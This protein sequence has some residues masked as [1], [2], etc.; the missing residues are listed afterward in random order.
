MSKQ[1][2]ALIAVAATAVLISKWFYDRERKKRENPNFIPK[3]LLAGDEEE[4][5]I[6][7][8]QPALKK[9]ALEAR[10]LSNIGQ[11]DQLMLYGLYK[12]ATI[13]NSNIDPPSKFRIRAYAKHQAWTKF[14]GM[15]RQFAILKY[16]EVVTHFGKLEQS[17][18][19]DPN[20]LSKDNAA[21]MNTISMIT[22]ES[23]ADIEYDK[24]Q[25]YDGE[26]LSDDDEI[27]IRRRN[28][29]NEDELASSLG[30]KQSTLIQG[31]EETAL[32]VD[33]K[34]TALQAASLGNPI[35]LQKCIDDGMNIEEPDE[36]GQTPLHMAAD[37][38]SL[39][40]IMILLKNGA[41]INVADNEG[42][43][44]LHAAVIRGS[45]D[46]TTFLLE[47]GG[48]PDIEDEDGESPRT[49]V[50]EDSNDA[51]KALFR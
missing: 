11:E 49:Y 20:E 44:P 33:G 13:G 31:G 10:E 41:D 24:D 4:E 7:L 40:C 6:A 25:E 12:Q 29:S 28:K 21:F 8:L 48:N 38:G 35:L 45:L 9:A 46:V 42:T 17:D 16:I 19:K 2:A 43:T 37:K 14:H 23:N 47:N 32:S 27:E 15:P 1:K 3:S 50:M 36:T 22:G 5:A 18:P 26:D 34:M 30:T 39:D 51:M